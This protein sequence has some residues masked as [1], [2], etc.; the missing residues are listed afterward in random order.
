MGS[1]VHTRWQIERVHVAPGP[2]AWHLE[3]SLSAG[4]YLVDTWDDTA[5]RVTRDMELFLVQHG[6]AKTETEDPERPLNDRGAETVRRMAA[7]ALQAGLRV[8][9]IRH[10]GKRRAEQTAETLA[11]HLQPARGVIAVAGLK[12]NDDVHSMAATLEAE[13]E[14]VMLVGHLPFLGRLVGFLVAG[15][16]DATVVRFRNAG[17]VCLRREEERW[18]VNW[19]VP[20]ELV[21]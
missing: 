16:P 9:Q 19:T 15:D 4:L 3:V 21:Q 17:I 7:W 5:T 14:A 2:T 6:E 1:L 11:E 20:P 12:P 13:T 8:A 10:S 18:S